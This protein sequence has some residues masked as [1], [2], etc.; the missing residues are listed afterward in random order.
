MLGILKWGMAQI[1]W[2]GASQHQSEQKVALKV[3]LPYK[4]KAGLKNQEWGGHEIPLLD[5]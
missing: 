2:L 3:Y 1:W 4:Q 5:P